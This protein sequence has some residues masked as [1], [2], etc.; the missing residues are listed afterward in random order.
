[1]GCCSCF[2][3]LSKSRRPLRAICGASSQL[4]QEFLLPDDADGMDGDLYN[5]DPALML[6]GSNGE[7]QR[8]K[9]SSE[10]ILLHR[11]QSGTICREVPVKET[12]HVVR[13]EILLS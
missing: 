13:T 1:M 9:K 11:I 8:R 5:G 6:Y 10:Q 2:G 12:H 7:L 3:F 4:S